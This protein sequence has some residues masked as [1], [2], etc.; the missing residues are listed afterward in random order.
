MNGDRRATKLR[1]WIVRA[2]GGACFFAGLAVPLAGAPTD[3]PSDRRAP[4]VTT[5]A[6]AAPT[7]R[8]A[9]SSSSS[10]QTA[11]S[12]QKKDLLSALMAEH[13][14]ARPLQVLAVLPES[15]VAA[16]RDTTGGIVHEGDRVVFLGGP[17]RLLEGVV[18]KIKSGNLHV[19]YELPRTGQRDP[20]PDDWAAYVPAHPQPPQTRPSGPS[21]RPA[22]RPTARA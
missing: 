7:T 4:P 19:R 8:P 5:T 13:P 12:A 3:A 21:S 9:E 6:T 18:V 10:A 22:S 15:T 1:A 20:R 17:E 2:C 16:V 11:G 14:D